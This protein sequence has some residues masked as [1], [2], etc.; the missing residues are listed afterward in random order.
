MAEQ[1][2]IHMPTLE[3]YSE[4]FKNFFKFKRSEDGIL[5]VKMHT[6]GG[7]VHWS[8]QMHHAISE[9]WTAVGLWVGLLTSVLSHGGRTAVPARSTTWLA[10]LM[11]LL[12]SMTSGERMLALANLCVAVALV[13]HF[14]WSVRRLRPHRAES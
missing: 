7:H 8:Y 6:F 14:M 1:D 9:L 3:E 10:E 12:R 4:R 5:E 13:V 2:Y 11:A